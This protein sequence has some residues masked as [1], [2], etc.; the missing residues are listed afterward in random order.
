V[1]ADEFALQ[2]VFGSSA[3]TTCAGASW[4]DS[5]I[6]SPLGVTPALYTSTNYADSALATG[7]PN[8]YKPDNTGSNLMYAYNA[9]TGIGKRA[10][11]WRVILPASTATSAT[12]TIQ[13][14]VT[15]L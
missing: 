15:A 8:T 11:C 9:T 2:A 13:V 1:G 6:A 7:G 4:N 14:I 3:T 12:Q 10:L 5:A